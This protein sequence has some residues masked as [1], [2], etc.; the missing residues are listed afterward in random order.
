M[1]NHSEPNSTTTQT[2]NK[3]KPRVSEGDLG[4]RVSGYIRQ[5]YLIQAN[6]LGVDMVIQEIVTKVGCERGRL[7][8]KSGG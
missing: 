2:K 8:S 4:W 5:N 7:R 3:S 1:E 6:L